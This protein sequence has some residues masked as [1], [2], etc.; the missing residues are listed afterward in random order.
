MNTLR[1][2]SEFE[3]GS[4][5]LADT[6]QR[7]LAP[8]TLETVLELAAEAGR[9]E[10]A[11]RTRL[12]VG[13]DVASTT[14]TT[15]EMADAVAAFHF[16]DDVWARV[17]YD[18]IIAARDPK[19]SLETLVASLVPIYFGRVASFVIENRNVTTDQAE[20]RVERQAREFE[21]LKPYLVKRWTEAAGPSVVG[22][23]M[24][25]PPLPARDPHPGRQPDDRR[26]AHPPRC[27]DAG[28]AGR[29][30]V[31]ARD[32]RG[33][34]GDAAV[35]GRDPRPPRPAPP[36]AGPRLRPRR[37][38]HPPD[39]AHRPARGRGH[40][41]GL[42]RAGSRTSSSSAGAGARP[43]ASNGSGP[44]VFSPTIDEVVRDSPCDIAVVKQRGSKAHPSRPGP[45]PRR[46]ARRT[47]APL[48]RRHRH[49]SRRDGRRPPPRPAGGHPGRP[50]PGRARPRGL[51]QA[52]HHRPQRGRPA[53][54]A[55]RPQ[56]DPA[57]GGEGGP[58]GHGR[59]GVARRRGRRDVTC[60]VP[61]RRRSPPVPARRSWSSRPASRSSAR[62]ST[63]WPPGPRPW[64]PP[65]ARP[66][67][68]AP[69]RSGSS[70]GSA[71]RTSTTPS[72][73]TCAGW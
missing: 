39:R 62:P 38:D 35:R 6:W 53:R 22:R 73:P 58:R 47:R 24:A 42:G 7:M 26:G 27:R 21:L 51:H 63:S 64:P 25:R 37:N 32:R 1:L 61:C 18:M 10:D 57:R 52:A 71:N 43:V 23:L 70:A 16:P 41:R 29:R 12:G 2:L 49:P 60:S 67:R 56:R 45:G 8:A 65:T 13:G 68:R 40:H 44:T 46:A 72:S 4:L 20:E 3:A 17:I 69:S 33:P 30:A 59:V 14:A 28:P 9:L 48:R 66:R 5:T 11:A 36:P 19:P 54:G 50:G 31:G 34:R 55:Q 15:L